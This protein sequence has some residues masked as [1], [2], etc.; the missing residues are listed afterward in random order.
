VNND[1]SEENIPA[2]EDGEI[3]K[4]VPVQLFP[5]CI[6]RHRNLFLYFTIFTSRDIFF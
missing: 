5:E 1:V 2:G 4:Q 3:K 6:L